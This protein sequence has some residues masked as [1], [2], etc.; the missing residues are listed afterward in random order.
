MIRYIF[1]DLDGTLSD[2]SEGITKG[3]G[4]ALSKMGIE[5][6]R[7]ELLRYIGPPLTVSFGEHFSDPEEVQRGIRLY[8]EYYNE[9]GWKE[10]V[11]YPGIPEALKKLREAG[12]VLLMA[13]SKPELYAKRIADYFGITEYFHKICGA[14]MDGTINTKSEVIR[15]ALA[16]LGNPDPSE[17]LMIGDRFYDVEG[18]R[19]FGIRTLGVTYGFGNEEELL[20]A[21]AFAVCSSPEEMAELVLTL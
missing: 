9:T 19:P 2:S 3:I 1:F 7:E 21:G 12:K 20:K 4:G 8:R 14:T 16:G 13:T 11:L 5:L 17:V 10:N 18:A 6:G 15:Y